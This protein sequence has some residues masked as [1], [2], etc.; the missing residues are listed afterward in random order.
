MGERYSQ[1]NSLGGLFKV[2]SETDTKQKL[3]IDAQV[4]K[5]MYSVRVQ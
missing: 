5:K 3:H 2:Q 1:N 4:G